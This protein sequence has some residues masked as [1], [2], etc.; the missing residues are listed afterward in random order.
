MNRTLHIV[1]QAHRATLE[2]QDDPILWLVQA[3]QAGGAD[4]SVL[5]CGTAVGYGILGQDASGLAFG[6]H[7]QTQPPRIADDLERMLERGI[8]IRFVS[9]DAD[10][11]GLPRDRLVPGLE[12]IAREKVAELLGRFDRVY[13]W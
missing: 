10:E 4:A 2:E 1:R 6:A 12:P 3:M 7:R 11:R 8:P 9:E 5:L 13:A